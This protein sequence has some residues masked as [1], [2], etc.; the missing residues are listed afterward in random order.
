[1]PQGSQHHV[2]RR[3]ATFAI[4]EVRK[5]TPRSFQFGACRG[6][7][8]AD[9]ADVRETDVR[10][11]RTT[12]AGRGDVGGGIFDELDDAVVRTEADDGGPDD[13]RRRE[14]LTHVLLDPRAFHRVGR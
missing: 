7:V 6:E 1:M 10:D 5:A 9:Q 2:V 12:F 4:P 3:P 11:R 8:L 14:E 13:D